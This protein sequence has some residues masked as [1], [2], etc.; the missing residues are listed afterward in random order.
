[1]LA[2]NVF[3]AFL[4]PIILALFFITTFPSNSRLSVPAFLFHYAL[5]QVCFWPPAIAA[6]FVGRR[7][8][9]D[10]VLRLATL[11]AGFSLVLSLVFAIPFA[12][13]HFEPNYGWKAV[14]R[15]T[16]SEAVAAAGAYIIYR[17]VVG[18]STQ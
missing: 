14:A 16:L 3:A 10:S 13:L 6:E 18:R 1:M 7:L 17:A 2:R 11:M 12:F 8:R 4:A 15:D 5:A 9:F